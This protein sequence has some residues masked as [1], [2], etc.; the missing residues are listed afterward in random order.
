M[1]S[2]DKIPLGQ[3][4]PADSFVHSLDP[5]AKIIVTIIAMIAIFMLHT[6]AGLRALRAIHISALAACAAALQARRRVV[7]SCPYSRYIYGFISS[8][9]H[10]GKSSF[11]ILRH[12]GDRRRRFARPR[13]GAAA[14]ISR[15]VRLASDLHDDACKDFRR[16]RRTSL[17]AE[18]ARPSRARHSD[19]DNHR[20]ALHSDAF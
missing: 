16:P 9:P 8:F 18:T 17:A 20:A 15:H 12:R 2:L 5:R 7:A 10:A 6:G 11:F 4:I 13:N 14:H 1:A 19:D 3:Y